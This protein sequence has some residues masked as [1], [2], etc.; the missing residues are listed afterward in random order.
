MQRERAL[1]D[2]RR[3]KRRDVRAAPVSAMTT[4][5][6]V[7]QPRHGLLICDVAGGAYE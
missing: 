6:I 4:D 5:D 7:V 1:C 2:Q 3:D